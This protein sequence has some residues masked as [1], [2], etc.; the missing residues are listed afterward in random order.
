MSGFL[1]GF[2]LNASNV[3]PKAEPRRLYREVSF[4]LQRL[5]LCALLP[6]SP[7]TSDSPAKNAP[8]GVA[9]RTPC[10]VSETFRLSNG[11]HFELDALVLLDAADDLEEVAGVR[12]ASRSE[13]A[14]ETVGRLIGDGGKLL[15]PDGGVDIAAQLDLADIDATIAM[16][17]TKGRAAQLGERS[18][19]HPYTGAMTACPTC[20]VPV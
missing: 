16:P 2:M 15:E 20:Q 13:H 11:P 18:I 5:E 6:S 17:A 1:P 12:I 19:R 3:V 7:W 14:H 4:L 9:S 8:Y 10:S